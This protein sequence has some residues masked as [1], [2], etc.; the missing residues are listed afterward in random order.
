MTTSVEPDAYDDLDGFIANLKPSGIAVETC[1]EWD[2]EVG[3]IARICDPEGT[4]VEL[5]EP[6]KG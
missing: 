2:L 5:W 1:A 4:P 6:A 3:R